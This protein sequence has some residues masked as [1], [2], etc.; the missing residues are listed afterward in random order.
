MFLCT[1]LNLFLQFQHSVRIHVEGAEKEWGLGPL[2]EKNWVKLFIFVQKY[3][4]WHI[5]IVTE[6]KGLKWELNSVQT[7][8]L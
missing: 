8:F 2:P 7:D 5:K 6:G 1:F 4:I 3:T